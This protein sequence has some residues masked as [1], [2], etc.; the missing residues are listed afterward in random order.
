MGSLSFT[1]AKENPAFQQAVR[2]GL[3]ASFVLAAYLVRSGIEHL[4]DVTLFPFVT[5]YPM[6]I[7][8]AVLW[9]PWMG[10]LATGLSAVFVLKPLGSF[11]LG[12]WSEALTLAFFTLNCVLMSIVA[13]RY[14]RHQRQL[15]GMQAQEAKRE[16]EERYRTA[17][18]TSMDAIAISRARD[19]V[20]LDANDALLAMMGYTREELIGHSALELEIWV[21]VE[22]REKVIEAAL[23]STDNRNRLVQLRKKSGERFTALLS[24]APFEMAGEACVHSAVRDLTEV[25][26]AEE[27]IRNLSF[28]DP[29][30]ELANRRLVM[31]RL[32][33]SIAFGTRTGQMRA[34]LMADLDNFKMLNETQG[35]PAGDALLQEMAR[36]LTACVRQVDTVGRLGGDEFA[37]L[38]EDLGKTA[39]EAADHA[40]WVAEKVLAAVAQPCPI[41][42][43]ECRSTCSIGISVFGTDH[44]RVE[45]EDVLRQAELAMYQAK[46]AGRNAM[47]FYSPELQEA[48]RIRAAMEEEMRAGIGGGEFVLYYQPQVEAGK[49]AGAEALVRWKHPQRGMLA[50]GAFIKLAE[51]TRLILPLGRWILEEACAQIVAWEER[52]QPARLTVGVNI[53]PL[54]LAHPDFVETV[55]QALEKTG[56]N[57][58]LLALELTESMLVDRAEDVTAEMTAL[59]ERGVRFSID[60]FG[61]GYSSLAYLKRL[62]LDQLKIDRSFV[63]DIPRNISSTAI[64][65][66]VITLSMVLGLSVIAEGV[67]TEEQ[68]ALLDDMGCHAFQGYLFGKPMPSEAFEALIEQ[69]RGCFTSH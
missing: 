18:Q 49:L 26:G 44:I 57:P 13:D 25:L 65:Q 66:T 51:E 14:R 62:P 27:Q 31:E 15:A 40:R 36:R 2:A 21:N 64:V 67:E 20:Y 48:V 35:H 46:A 8:V 23:H 5:F 6:V 55:L 32:E 42:G 54:Q 24:A 12:E 29:L 43:V 53:S 30:T 34:L 58:R 28:R 16:S 4:F 47:S 10:L 63:R 56:A 38:L 19:G 11:Q 39:E 17:F 59:R 50:P 7:I 9:G 37:L 52:I 22:E 1:R 68:R 3:T 33:R 61:T 60:D 41:Q 45:V 69:N